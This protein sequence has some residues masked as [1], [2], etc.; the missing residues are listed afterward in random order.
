MFSFS[1]E[2]CLAYEAIPVP[3]AYFQRSE[4]KIVPILVSDGLCKMIGCELEQGFFFYKPEP[5]DDHIFKFKKRV[6]NHLSQEQIDRTLAW[7]NPE[8]E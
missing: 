8:E 2:V 4:D 7:I 5:L 1:E 3:L 6:G